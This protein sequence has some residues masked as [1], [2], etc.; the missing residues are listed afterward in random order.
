MMRGPQGPLIS[1]L[2]KNVFPSCEIAERTDA[3]VTGKRGNPDEHRFTCQRSQ[4]V[5]H[6]RTRSVTT[7]RAV[8]VLRASDQ[9]GE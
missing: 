1:P 2:T 8:G 3:G 6:E 5:S 9:W 4:Q 7:E